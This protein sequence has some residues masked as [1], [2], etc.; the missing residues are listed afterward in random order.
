[1]KQL[2]EPKISRLQPE[3]SVWITVS[4]NAACLTSISN[5]MTVCLISLTQMF[6]ENLI[7]SAEKDF[8]FWD[9]IWAPIAE[10]NGT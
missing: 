6:L 10:L 8:F 9:D 3:H 2:D 1:M 4:H 5:V 7:Q